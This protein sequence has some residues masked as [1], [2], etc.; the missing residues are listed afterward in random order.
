[1]LFN[2]WFECKRY[3]EIRKI[4]GLMF[5]FDLKNIVLRVNLIELKC[6]FG[7]DFLFVG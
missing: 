3:D 4:V 1:M 5:F 2:G 7:L 6:Y